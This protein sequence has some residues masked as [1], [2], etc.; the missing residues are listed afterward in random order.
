[1][2]DRVA[3]VVDGFRHLTDREKVLAYLEIEEIWKGLP[4]DKAKPEKP[5]SPR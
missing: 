2:E 5:Y 3:A 4:K 1:M